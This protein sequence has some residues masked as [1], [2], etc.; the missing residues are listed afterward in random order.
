MSVLTDTGNR[1]PKLLEQVRRACRARQ[2]SRRTEHAYTGWVRRYVLFHGKRHPAALDAAAISGFLSHLANEGKISASTQSQ[3]ASALLFLYREV[4]GVPID[5]PR[6]VVRPRKPRR[7]PI[8][9][10]RP[11]VSAVLAELGGVKRLVASLLYGSGLRLREALQLRA[12]DVNLQR[13]E[14]VVRH[15]KGG[16]DRVT[17]LPGVLVPDMRR[18]LERVRVQH[19]RHVERGGGWTELPAGL[20]RKYPTAGRELPWQWT[21]PATRCYTDARQ[22]RGGSIT[23]TRVPFNAPSPRPFA[24]RQYPSVRA[25]I[26]S[27]TPSRHTYSRTATTFELSKSCSATK[28]S[29][30]P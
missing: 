24:A 12:K 26:R 14:L 21:F 23:F 10:T 20:A 9:L 27:G 3:A 1:R 25:A 5:P 28:A 2:Y 13:R 7:L 11:E 6:G 30:R 29:R 19:G 17:M 4:L 16:H 22:V 15:G 8:V 18:Q